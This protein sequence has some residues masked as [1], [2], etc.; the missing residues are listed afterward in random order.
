MDYCEK[1]GVSLL[2]DRSQ[3]FKHTKI[4]GVINTGKHIRNK[5]VCTRCFR[6]F[7]Q[8]NLLIQLAGVDFPNELVFVYHKPD[9]TYLDYLKNVRTTI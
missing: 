8:D 2:Q 9:I 3:Y 1:C 5:I 7:K 4:K 6:E